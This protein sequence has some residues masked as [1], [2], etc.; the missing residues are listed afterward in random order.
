MS[1]TIK[2]IAKLV[3]VS[4]STVSRALN[5]SS[6][7]SGETRNR[8]Q[9]AMKQL[10]YHPNSLAKS[11][12]TGSTGTIALIIDADNE[13]DF[14][15]NFFNRSMFAMERIAQA[16][17]YNLLIT[18]DNEKRRVIS[19]LVYE[20]KADG[21]I[22]PSSSVNLHLMAMLDKERFPYVVMGS[23]AILSD[24]LAWVDVDNEQGS[25]IAVRHLAE[26]GYRRPAL[27]IEN[28]ETVFAKSRVQGF[29]KAVRELEG[30]GSAVI[31]CTPDEAALGEEL[32]AALEG[33]R[34]DAF[35]C[36]NNELAFRTLQLLRARGLRVP[37]DIGLVTFDN[38]P[39]AEYMDP[40]VT[41]VDVDTY[42]LGRMA[43]E[44]LFFRIKN[45]EQRPERRLLR[46]ELIPRASSGR[47]G[48]KADS[49]CAERQAGGK[50]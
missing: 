42:E 45:R 15:N 32:A 17:G 43:A 20:K 1:A 4:P 34:C 44:Y 13:K 8:I 36:A 35:L 38:Y 26:E 9:K 37:E 5:G 24:Q 49:A 23:P 10:D 39:F 40:P 31:C 16:N 3:G 2:D 28:E 50:R 33:G 48:E 11:F 41:A 29:R 22:I 7:I 27:V 14:A 30:G 6:L 18:N 46:T 47:R 25:G 21:L 12:A 19:S